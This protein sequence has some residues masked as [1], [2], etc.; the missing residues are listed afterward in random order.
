[1]P[2]PRTVARFNRYVTNPIVRR[3]AGWVPSFCI[4]TH[5][6]RRTGRQYRIPLNVLRTEDG[7]VFALTYGPGADWVKNVVTAGTC[8]VRY[9]SEDFRLEDPEFLA[10]ETGMSHMPAPVRVML[11]LLD[12]TEFLHLRETG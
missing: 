7:F 3:F 4:M 9:R 2:I 5:I 10:T 11:R 6:G 1:M 12:V 8:A